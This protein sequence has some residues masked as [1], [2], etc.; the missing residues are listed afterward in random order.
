MICPA[1]SIKGMGI[2][3]EWKQAIEQ[4]R[5]L[6]ISHFEKNDGVQILD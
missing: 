5:F 2:P 6:L 1:R 4:K 3:S